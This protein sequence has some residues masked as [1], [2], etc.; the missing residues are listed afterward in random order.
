MFYKHHS[1][2]IWAG[3]G[4][5]SPFAEST[6]VQLINFRQIEVIRKTCPCDLYS[7]TP[8]FYKVKLGFT[9]VFICFYFCSKT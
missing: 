1:S 5:F 7:F 2:F 8:H 6:G 3:P 9:W 4:A